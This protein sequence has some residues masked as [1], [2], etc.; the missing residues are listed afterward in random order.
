[1][2]TTGTVTVTI[3]GTSGSL[4]HT[5][6]FSLTVRLIPTLPSVWT[7]GDIGAPGVAGSASYA[8]NVFTV[9]GAGAQIYGTADA[10]HFVYQPLSG[11]GTIIARLVSLQGGSGYVSA[12]VM[13]REALSAGSTNAKTADWAAYG[14]IYFD[15][16]TATG[17]STSEPGSVG[18]TL[19]YWVKVARSG[20][21]FSSSASSDGVNWVQLG[22]SQTINMG[23]NVYVGL[24]VNSG[25]NSAQATATFDNVSVNSAAVPAPVITSVSATTGLIG[26]QVVITGTGFGATQGSSMVLLNGTQATVNSWGATSITTTIPAGATSGL[27]V[28]SVAPGMNDSN[29][30]VFTVTSHLPNSWLDQD[31]GSVGDAGGASFSNGTFTVSGA[32]AQIYGTADAFHFV[33]QPLSG[34]GTIIARLVSL[35]GGTGYVSAGVMIREALS[36]GSTNAKTADWPSYGGIYFDVRT[37]TGGGTSEPGRVSATLPYWLKVTRS[38]STF[39]SY[40]SSDGANWVQL[41][42]SQTISMA[43]NVFVGLAVTSGTPAALATATFDNASIT[44]P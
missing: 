11:D 38:G 41:G 39:T 25:S 29:P 43:Q 44:S 2:A 8:N 36:A 14:G 26:S 42:A 20:S 30:V 1:M 5:T 10:F 13:I 6:S 23:Q 9:S 3:T 33:Y 18:A 24:A 34:D 15:V 17:G 7:D 16:R 21:S 27:L 32:G 37:T 28:V 22:T 12:G 40:T 35:Q 31:V 4:T 19:P